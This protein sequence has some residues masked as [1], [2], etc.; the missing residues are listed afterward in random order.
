MSDTRNKLLSIFAEHQDALTRLLTRR[1]GSVALVED[2]IQ[3]TWLRAANCK[4]TAALVNPQ[5]YLFRIASNLA[6]D[7][8]RH[9][10]QRI[11]VRASEEAV[12]AVSDPAPSPEA[13]AVHRSELDRLLRIVGGLS[14]RCREVF[15]LHKFEGLPYNEVAQRLGISRNTVMVHMVKA[16]A[17]LEREMD[18]APAKIASKA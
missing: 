4:G 8:L 13:A 17:A 14:P 1:L 6:L 10:G 11:E 2:L 3:E 9:V 5:A 12:A 7:H 18:P 15:I 16:L